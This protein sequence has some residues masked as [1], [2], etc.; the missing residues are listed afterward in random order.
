MYEKH[1][2]LDSTLIFQCIN[3]DF[4]CAAIAT[5]FTAAVVAVHP[6]FI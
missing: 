1:V 4:I 3:I 2:Y 6:H 5:A